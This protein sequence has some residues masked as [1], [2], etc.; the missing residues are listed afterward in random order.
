MTKDNDIEEGMGEFLRDFGIAQIATDSL[1]LLAG[2]ASK[3]EPITISDLQQLANLRAAAG[4]VYQ[5]RFPKETIRELESEIRKAVVPSGF[6]PK[7]Q[8]LDPSYVAH[9]N[10]HEP[11]MRITLSTTSKLVEAEKK[12]ARDEYMSKHRPRKAG[13][14]V[15]V[16]VILGALLAE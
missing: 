14:L 10:P 7:L 3:G 16:A 6:D 11:E 4:G 13:C 15:L 5:S 12:R 9:L 1:I 2:R 8:N